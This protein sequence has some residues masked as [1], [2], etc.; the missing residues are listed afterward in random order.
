VQLCMPPIGQPCICQPMT[1]LYFV[2]GQSVFVFVGQTLA[3]GSAVERDP[4]RAGF[5]GA[6]GGAVQLECS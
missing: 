4:L 2:F 6:P 3:V 5:S 1:W